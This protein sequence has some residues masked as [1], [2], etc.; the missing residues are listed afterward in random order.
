MNLR[1]TFTVA[2]VALVATAT[3]WAFEHRVQKVRIPFEFRAGAASLPSGVYEV[4]VDASRATP[5]IRMSNW[6]TRQAVMVLAPL[7]VAADQD[8]TGSEARLIFLCAGTDCALNEVQPGRGFAG[9]QTTKPKFRTEMGRGPSQRPEV[10]RVVI[11]A[12][13]AD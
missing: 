11:S 7:K 5:V 8:L 1:S 9:Y 6:E 4:K 3:V 10:A 12:T 13:R 2:A